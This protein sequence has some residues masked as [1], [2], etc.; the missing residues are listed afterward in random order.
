[1][2]SPTFENIISFIERRTGFKKS[3]STAIAVFLI[4]ICGMILHRLLLFPLLSPSFD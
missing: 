2:I 3:W 1:L 4:N